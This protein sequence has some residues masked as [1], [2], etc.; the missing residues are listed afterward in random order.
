MIFKEFV[1]S[2]NV[3]SEM[4]GDCAKSLSVIFERWFMPESDL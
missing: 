1:G 4:L 2:D 3:A